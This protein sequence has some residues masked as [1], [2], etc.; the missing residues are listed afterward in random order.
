MWR[1]H[2]SVYTHA[3]AREAESRSREVR[4][5]VQRSPDV[6]D[7]VVVEVQLL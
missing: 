3:R 4:H 1:L 2:E 5:V 7:L 6:L